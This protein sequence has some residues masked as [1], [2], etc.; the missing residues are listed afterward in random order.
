MVE[1]GV[2]EEEMCGE[3]NE[4]KREYLTC[5]H[6]SVLYKYATKRLQ[7]ERLAHKV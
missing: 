4:G 6:P 2:R 5:R 7:K 3:G 1:V